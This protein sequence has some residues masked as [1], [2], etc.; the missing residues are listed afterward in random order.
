MINDVFLGWDSN[1]ASLLGREN[2]IIEGLAP[3][4]SN[5]AKFFTITFGERIGP[6]YQKEQLFVELY[7]DFDVFVHDP[8]FFTVN[9]VPVALP[10]LQRTV[11]VN[12]SENHFYYLLMT[13]VEELDLTQDRC[14]TDE[15]YDFQVDHRL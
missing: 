6:D 4:V 8:E 14:N 5:R 10:A 9:Y 15:K 12:K 3:F 7:D 13:E 11:R 1:K 2:L